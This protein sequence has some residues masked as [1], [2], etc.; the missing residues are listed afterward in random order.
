MKIKRWVYI[1]RAKWENYLGLTSRRL[2]GLFTWKCKYCKS[3]LVVVVFRPWILGGPF[4]WAS[5][6]K[7]YPKANPLQLFQRYLYAF[8]APCWD[9]STTVWYVDFSLSD[10]FGR[11]LE[12]VSPSSTSGSIPI[13]KSQS[14]GKKKKKKKQF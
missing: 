12:K 5:S 11:V 13:P 10:P 9:G 7:D 4:S 1:T 14:E 3:F 6:F 2:L 8:N